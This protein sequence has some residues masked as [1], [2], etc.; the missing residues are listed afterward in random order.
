MATNDILK[1]AAKVALAVA[2][3]GTVKKL[4]ENAGKDIKSLPNNRKAQ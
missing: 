4:A 1:I 2:A 3:F